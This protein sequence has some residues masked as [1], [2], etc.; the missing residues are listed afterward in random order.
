MVCMPETLLYVP[1]STLNLDNQ[2]GID[3]FLTS[4]CFPYVYSGYEGSG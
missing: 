1:A 4:S 3:V 2:S